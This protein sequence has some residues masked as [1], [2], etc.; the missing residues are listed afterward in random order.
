MRIL[1]VLR[2]NY[3]AGQNEFIQKNGLKEFT[4]DFNDLRFLCNRTKQLDN[5]YKSLDYKNDNELYKFL[6]FCLQKRMEKGD[7]CVINAYSQTLKTYKDLAIY[8][9][10]KM[11]IIDFSDISLQECRENNLIYAERQGLLTP[12]S[13]LQ[14]MD[15]MLKKP[16]KKY[17][18]LKPSEW[19]KCLYEMPNL[20][21]YKKIHHIGDIQGCYSVLRTY[22]KNIKDDEYYIFLGDYIDRGIENGKVMKYLLKLCKKKNVCLLEGN[23]ERHLIKWANGELVSSSEFN[24]NTLKDFRKEKLTPRDAREFYP[25]LKECLLYEYDKKKIF[26]SHGGVNT[27]PKKPQMLSFVPSADFIYGV[28]NYEQSEEIAMQFCENTSK[29]VYEIFGHRNRSK[30]PMQIASRAYLCEGKVDDGGHLRVVVLSKKGFEC[31]EIKNEV[32]RKK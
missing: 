29:N 26:C 20:S 19:S 30:L 21:H 32:Y 10:Y 13:I 22:L 11:F 31:I 17:A 3:H 25:Y 9:R 14:N 1:L 12:D 15:K 23:H 4:L 2:G 5:A 24:V 6:L 8:Y 28:G 7:F 18:V 16:P 27:L